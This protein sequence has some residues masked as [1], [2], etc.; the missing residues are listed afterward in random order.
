[1]PTFHFESIYQGLRSA[2]EIAPALQFLT[3][4]DDQHLNI[5]VEK[6]DLASAVRRTSRRHA[7]NTDDG[8]APIVEVEKIFPEIAGYQS[9][10]ALDIHL[11]SDCHGY[12]PICI[13][14]Q[15]AALP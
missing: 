7:R 14:R 6:S 5:P 13:D 10:N 11:R 9:K 2:H 8:V 4:E 15:C 1:M 3:P 12:P